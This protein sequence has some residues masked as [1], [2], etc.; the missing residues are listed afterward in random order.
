MDKFT[1]KFIPQVTL[2]REPIHQSY[3]S[4]VVCF[5][6][7]CL[8]RIK[9]EVYAEFRVVTGTFLSVTI[10]PYLTVFSVNRSC[11]VLTSHQTNEFK[12]LLKSSF[13]TKH[14]RGNNIQ[15]VC[16][17]V[18]KFWGWKISLDSCWIFKMH[19]SLSLFFLKTWILRYMVLIGHWW[20]TH[21]TPEYYFCRRNYLSADKQKE[22]Y[23]CFSTLWRDRD[24]DGNRET[25]KTK[26]EVSIDTNG[27]E[28]KLT[29]VTVTN[30]HS[31]C[32][33]LWLLTDWLFD[34]R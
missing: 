16:E 27:K 13:Q 26:K 15:D 2:C 28:R 29:K 12:K 20:Y 17:V 5:P 3:A 9:T 21:T 14:T 4:W 22:N 32:N 18:K 7:M 1:F 19:F 6:T 30:P 10:K 24:G 25:E 31:K 23:H 34:V 8:R 11:Q 33:T